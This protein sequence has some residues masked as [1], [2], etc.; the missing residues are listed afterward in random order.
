MRKDGAEVKRV[1][2]IIISIA[3]IMCAFASAMPSFA[4]N[5]STFSCEIVDNEIIIV[6]YFGTGKTSVTVPTSLDGKP[7]VAIADGAFKGNTEIISVTVKSGVR[8]IGASAFEDCISLATIS[9][10]DTITHIGEKAIYNT[11]YYNNKS[12][13][14]LKKTQGDSSSGKVEIG[15]GSGMGSIDWE[16]ISAPVLQYL[17]LGTNLIEIEL[18]GI[19]SVN[20]GTRVIADG[21]FKGNAKA[22]DVGLPSSM[23]AIGCNAFEGCTS[24]ESVRNLNVVDCIGDNAFKDC[25]SLETLNVSETA[26]FNANAIYNTG[27]Y[28]NVE[29]WE[30]GVLYMGDRVVSTD[31]N[32]VETIIK[33]GATEIIGGAL[34][35]KNVVIPASVVNIADNAFVSVENV[36]IFG[37]SGTYTESYA[38]E[39]NIPFVALDATIKGDVNF[40]GILDENDLEILCAV[41]ALQKCESYAISLVGDMNEDG[42]VDG[43][44]TIILDLFLKDIPPSTLKG[45][46]NGDGV[47]DNDDYQLL[48]LISSGN[49]IVKNN[50]MFN[51]CDLNE[52][53][54]VDGFD[55]V[56][57]DL[58]LNGL[59]I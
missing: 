2:S 25:T 54:A 9:L 57:L 52:D 27:Y 19:Y 49:E 43:F 44:D 22:K 35:D 31:T 56:Y 5:Y 51:R 59:A 45:D 30:N 18:E 26:N 16:D 29:N 38:N 14:K 32:S 8:D 41:S 28:N 33:D 53:G 36:T 7:V 48:C 6:K 12:N 1:I 55:V 11:A 4:V 46:A 20:Y 23:V 10:P 15:S 58:I 3:I 21:A 47:L 37:L 24:L 42:A 13:W 34:N 39:K 50:F 40:N 17:Y